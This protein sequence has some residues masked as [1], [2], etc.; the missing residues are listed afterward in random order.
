MKEREARLKE[1][2]EFGKTVNP[3]ARWEMMRDYSRN[4]WHVSRLTAIDYMKI[5]IAIINSKPTE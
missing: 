1:L 4:K 2:V 5:A 3:N